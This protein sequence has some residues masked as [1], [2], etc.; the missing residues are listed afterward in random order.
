MVRDRIPLRPTEGGC[1]LH[2]VCV[3][4]PVDCG[5]YYICI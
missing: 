4:V 2:M 5:M 3:L 1:I